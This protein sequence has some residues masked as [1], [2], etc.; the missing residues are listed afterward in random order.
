MISSITGVGESSQVKISLHGDMRPTTDDPRLISPQCRDLLPVETV[1][2]NPWFCVK[3]RGGFY[4]IEYEH[5]QVLVLPIVDRSSIVM[6]RA[7][8]PI[9]SDETLELPAGSVNKDETPINGAVREFV[10]ETGIEINEPNRFEMLP[11][12]VHTPRSPCL[13]YIFQ[14]HLSQQEY[15][16]RAFHDGEIVGVE[17]LKF[18]DVQNKIGAGEIYIGLQIAILMRFFLKNKI[19][20]FKN[21]I[22]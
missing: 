3:N 19:V 8:R 21:G 10:E 5:P 6:V 14:I 9:I 22:Y 20:V 17:C 7:Y 4:T 16:Q 13:P 11:P 2:E 18:N 15:D 1:H 12:L